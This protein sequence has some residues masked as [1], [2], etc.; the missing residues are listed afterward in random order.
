MT[1]DLTRP[2]ET[3]PAGDAAPPAGPARA[4]AEAPGVPAGT[5]PVMA[6]GGAGPSRA[7]WAIGLGVAGLAVVGAI[8][9]FI[10]LGSRPTPEALKY[11]PGDAAIVVE[12]RMDL[13]GD[14]MQKLGNLLAH[15]P[16]FA[17]QSTLPAKIDESLSRIVQQGGGTDIDY[18]RDIKPWLSGPTFIAMRLP[19]SA[20]SGEATMEHGVVSATTT[21]TVTCDTPLRGQTVTKETY[22]GLELSIGSGGDAACVI[23]G[24]QALLGDA[25]SVRAALDA[26]ASGSG[27]DKSAEYAKARAALQGDQLSTIFV[28]GKAYSSLLSSAGATTPGM[29][30]LAALIGSVPDWAITGIRAEDDALVLDSLAAPTSSASPSGT[31]GPSLLPLPPTHASAIAPL[32]PADTIVYAEAQGAGVGLQNLISRVRTIP[33]LATAFQML[34][35][36]GGAGQ[37]VGWVE[38]AGVIVVK[39]GQAPSGGLALVAA[40]DAAAADRIK[41]LTGLLAFAG[42]GNNSVQ[43]RTL[44]IAG[45]TVTT[46]T[47][48]N[49]SSFVPPGQLPPGVD[50][51]AD[52][53]VEFSLAAKGRVILLGTGEDFMTAVLGT[54]PGAGLADQA[55]YKLAMSRALANSRG[56]LYV[57][58]HDI[59]GLAETFLPAD[60]ASQ[61]EANLK[62]YV[63]P[64]QALSITSTDDPSG[65]HQRLTVTVGQP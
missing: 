59:V 32:A 2:I 18:V 48:S 37:L 33:E 40:D 47:I 36:M 31:A 56:T 28:N 64:F 24:R 49:L 45:V 15:F 35:G 54:Q 55:A 9:A 13:P 38:D 43:T 52:A 14:Q 30:N 7:R 16:G 8:V 44:T 17:D 12:V 1:D 58:I 57:G 10:V 27:M 63:A 34:D 46:V 25:A 4:P 26:K 65:A 5:Q 62:P 42:L 21:G 39:G 29:S 23:D 6:G 22:R 19:A 3:P 60:Q 51:P 61:W 41:T 11:I 53:K 50:V 20:S